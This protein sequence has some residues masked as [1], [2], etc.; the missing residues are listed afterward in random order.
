MSDPS[1][2]D[3][4]AAQERFAQTIFEKVGATESLLMAMR[5]ILL[6]GQ[7]K[8]ENEEVVACAKQALTAIKRIG[9]LT[10]A[11]PPVV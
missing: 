6:V 9:V 8:P 10:E 2:D 3:R 1:A 7:T 4:T 5:L 11:L